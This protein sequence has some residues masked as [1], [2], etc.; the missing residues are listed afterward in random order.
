MINLS[1]YETIDPSF[2]THEN[3]IEFIRMKSK[4]LEIKVSC[5]IRSKISESPLLKSKTRLS[6]LTMENLEKEMEIIEELKDYAVVCSSWIP[7]KSYYLFFNLSL[8]L[9]YLISGDGNVLKQESHQ[10]LLN[11]LKNRI[12][13]KELIFSESCFNQV[14]TAAEIDQWKFEPG[15]NLRTVLQIDRDKQIVKKLLNYSKE[16]FRR[17]NKRT[18]SGKNKSL[19]YNHTKISL[20]GFFY[21]YRIK[22][23]YR[24]LEFLDSKVNESLFYEYYKNY[25]L[26]SKR[27][28]TAFVREINRLANI[29]FGKELF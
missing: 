16:E 10:G 27:F 12:I 26:A 19:F 28:Y 1:Q 11:K 15:N 23:N 4:N 29:R 9:E 25:Y 8:I 3:Y 24:D 20:I 13:S 18:I 14:Y 2:L 5:N 21:W 17:R 22:V 7:V 6:F